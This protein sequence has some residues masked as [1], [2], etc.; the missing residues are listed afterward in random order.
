LPWKSLAAKDD[1]GLTLRHEGAGRPWV[2][3]Q[4]LAAVPLKAPFEAGYRLS[5]KIEPVEQKQPGRYSRGDILRIT[6]DIDA[7]ADMSWVVVSDPVPAGATVLGS[8]LG[9]DS[10]IAVVGNRGNRGKGDAWL[11]FEE[12]SFDAFRAYYAW[13]PAGKFSI[14]YTLRL[15]NPGKFGMPPSRVE[16]LYAPERHAMT[17]VPPLEVQ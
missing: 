17:P 13:A 8:S 12:R 16:A 3:L 2:T 11:A 14:S 10:A 1:D 4:S 6:L 15:N 9:R 7:Q 5:R